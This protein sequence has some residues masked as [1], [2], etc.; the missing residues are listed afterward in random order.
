MTRDRLLNLSGP[1]SPH[2]CN[3]IVG[4][5]KGGNDVMSSGQSLVLLS[6]WQLFK[7]TPLSDEFTASLS[8]R[9]RVKVIPAADIY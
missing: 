1:Q 4:R 5:I 6:K 3:G 9:E 2:L 7:L 8:I